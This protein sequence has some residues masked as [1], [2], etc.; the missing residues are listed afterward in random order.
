MHF[1]DENSSVQIL[2]RFSSDLR[3]VDELLTETT[4]LESE[5]QSEKPAVIT[6]DWPSSGCIEFRNVFYRYFAE[7]KPVLQELSFVIK[8]KEK[9]GI[10]G[11]TGAGKS[12][13]IGAL[14][15]LASV[16]GEI[17]IDGID[18]AN[19]QLNDLRKRIAIIPQ[20]PVL[21]SGTLRRNL[22]PFEEYSDPDIWSAL[23]SVGLKSV[24]SRSWGSLDKPYGEN[25]SVGQRQLLCLAR[26]ILRKNRILV[27]DEATANVDPQTDLLI[28]QTIRDRFTEC[29]VLTVA[30]RLHTIID[31]DR[32]L[33]MDSGRAAEFDDP[34]TLLQNGND[35][36]YGMVKSL[37]SD[38]F[39]HFSDVAGN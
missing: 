1:F 17:L 7:A 29:T 11:R 15:R 5:K 18:T 35:I 22:D 26:A 28:Q 24:V 32:V 21:F 14:F 4:R 8:S 38:E 39:K 2:D 12:S 31:S 16:E 13:L 19:I 33:V 25:S 20:D 3:I 6:S 23:E 27:L 10:V 34:H 37:G 30:H 9:I 36:F